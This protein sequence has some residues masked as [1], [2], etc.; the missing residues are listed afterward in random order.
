MGCGERMKVQGK[1]RL[2]FLP[3]YCSFA[4]AS[5][6]GYV[7]SYEA[8]GSDLSGN[9]CDRSHKQIYWWPKGSSEIRLS[10]QHLGLKH[11]LTIIN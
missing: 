9:P 11:T 10:L 6:G 7:P 1:R 4:S 3:L 2:S 5:R 8:A